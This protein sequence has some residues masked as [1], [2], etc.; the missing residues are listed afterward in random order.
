MYFFKI[1]CRRKNEKDN[2]DIIGTHP[3][4]FIYILGR[5]EMKKIIITICLT[6]VMCSC[7]DAHHNFSEYSY[8]TPRQHDVLKIMRADYISKYENSDRL[9]AKYHRELERMKKDYYYELMSLTVPGPSWEIRGPLDLT[10]WFETISYEFKQIL[11]ID[12]DLEQLK[13]KDTITIGLVNGGNAYSSNIDSPITISLNEFAQSYKD[14]DEIYFY[15]SDDN[16]YIYSIEGGSSGF[17]LIRDVEI[18]FDLLL[19]RNMGGFRSGG[20]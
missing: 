14:G 15:H 10:E 7:R 18:L 6:L 19:N 5:E 12:L 20:K 9:N 1:L 16:S 8:K 4:L 3:I 17:I 13:K 2:Y 11:D